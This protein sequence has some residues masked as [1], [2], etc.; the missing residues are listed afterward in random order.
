MSDCT[1]EANIHT[2]IHTYIQTD[3][4]KEFSREK[5]G[6][7]GIHKVYEFGVVGLGYGL[8]V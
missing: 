4:Q 5:K 2:Y 7:I 3:R 1:A 6:D 8:W